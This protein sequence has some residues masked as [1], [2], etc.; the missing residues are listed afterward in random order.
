MS[1]ELNIL[2]VDDSKVIRSMLADALKS[3]GYHNV[4]SVANGKEAID[5]LLQVKVDLVISDWNM[6]ICSGFDLLKSIRQSEGYKDLPFIM[7]TSEK[8]NES[9]KAAME[10]GATDYIKKPFLKED[11]ALKIKSILEWS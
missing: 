1:S 10:A 4:I 6:P 8:G 7:L 9:F 2:I 11:V 3:V 5:M